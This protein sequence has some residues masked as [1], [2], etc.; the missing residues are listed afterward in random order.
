MKSARMTWC[1]ALIVLTS[2]VMS[3]ASSSQSGRS[4][5]GASSAIIEAKKEGMNTAHNYCEIIACIGEIKDEC[6]MRIGIMDNY[7]ETILQEGGGSYVL[8]IDKAISI[9]YLKD[10]MLKDSLSLDRFKSGDKLLYR[11]YKEAN[12]EYYARLHSSLLRVTRKIRLDEQAPGYK[13]T[14]RQIFQAAEALVHKNKAQLGA[15]T[16]FAKRRAFQKAPSGSFFIS[17]IR[18]KDLY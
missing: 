3:C 15:E 13:F 10:W 2:G 16:F 11:S 5:E 17:P 14:F 8:K 18:Q 12:T 7:D 1:I 4:K 9:E 6:E